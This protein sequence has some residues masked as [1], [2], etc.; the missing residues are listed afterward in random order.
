MASLITANIY[1]IV[2]PNTDKIYI[3][4]TKRT[5]LRRMQEHISEYDRKK[6]CC[7]SK[8]ILDA[9][10]AT[11]E[12][13]E[14]FNCNNRKELHQREGYYIKLY[15][16]ICVNKV[17]P[18]R[19]KAEHYQD[20]WDKYATQ[21]KQYQDTHKEQIASQ[22]KQY[23]D[24]HKEQLD[25]QR[26][27]YYEINKDQIL[28]RTKQYQITHKNEISARRKQKY[29]QAKRQA[30]AHQGCPDWLTQ[31]DPLLKLQVE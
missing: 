30:A 26:K 21:K 12:L 22:Q 25:V 6:Y 29:Q 10:N 1:K 16:N 13:I 31:S 8:I 23:R 9:G 20:N 19:T 14:V 7:T 15:I 17:I 18:D 28:A 5:L 4:S 11:I 3:G 24:T 2:S 27:A